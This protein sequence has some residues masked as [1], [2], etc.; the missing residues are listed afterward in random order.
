MESRLP[1][2]LKGAGPEADFSSSEP[3]LRPEKAAAA[4]TLREDWL[5]LRRH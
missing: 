2:L 5:N 4:A 3:V 1:D